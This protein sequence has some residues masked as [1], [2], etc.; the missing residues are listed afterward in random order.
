MGI[1]HVLQIM[2]NLNLPERS[3]KKE[4]F[5]PAESLPVRRNVESHLI[6]VFV[7]TRLCKTKHPR[8]RFQNF[9]QSYVLLTD[10]IENHQSQPDSMT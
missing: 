1:G 3:S 6:T 4:H 5:K 8:K 7:D 2:I 10:R 9:R